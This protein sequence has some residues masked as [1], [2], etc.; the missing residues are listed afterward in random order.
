[1]QGSKDKAESL[2]MLVDSETLDLATTMYVGNDVNDLPAIQLCGF[3]A[4]PSDAHAAVKTAVT[5]VLQTPGGQGVTR[6]IIEKILQLNPEKE[7]GK[8]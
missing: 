1:M 2:R 7:W 4:C 6:E 3:S 8:S 5:Q